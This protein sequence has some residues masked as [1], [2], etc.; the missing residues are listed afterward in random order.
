MVW[1]RV[2]KSIESLI[3]NL[4]YDLSVYFLTS[5][6]INCVRRPTPFL[7][8]MPLLASPR[9]FFLCSFGKGRRHISF[10][11][12]PHLKSS[13]ERGGWLDVPAKESLL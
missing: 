8:V 10:Y 12:T 3:I 11:T 4:F 2:G 5:F 7:F 6:S 1:E 9:F 13:V